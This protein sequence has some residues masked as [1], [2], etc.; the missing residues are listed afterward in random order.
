LAE[1]S[2]RSG[3]SQSS[4]TVIWAS[5]MVIDTGV[6]SQSS[7]RAL[8]AVTIASTNSSHLKKDPGSE[9]PGE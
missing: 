3:A 1:M 4:T 2:P 8:W 6:L 7:N 5:E 9:Y